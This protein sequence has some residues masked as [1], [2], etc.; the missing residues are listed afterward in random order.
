MPR[1]KSAISTTS[2]EPPEIPAGAHEEGKVAFQVRFDAAI[3]KKLKDAA[4][5]SGLSLNQLIQGI[6][7]ACAENLHM[8]EP[9]FRQEGHVTSNPV[10]KCVYFGDTGRMYDDE[11]LYIDR[12]TSGINNVPLAQKANIWFSLDYSDRRFKTY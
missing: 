5:E 7:N 11:E 10:K 3:H 9:K 1:K 12:Q 6:C 8:G 4:E 2:Q